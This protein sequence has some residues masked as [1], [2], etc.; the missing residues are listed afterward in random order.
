TIN[1]LAMDKTGQIIDLFNGKQDLKNKIIRTVGNG[2]ER[3]SED[4]LR[5]IRAIR[6][7]SQLGFTISDKTIENIKKTKEDI[8]ALEAERITNEITKLFRGEYV[9]RGIQYIK[10]T[11]IGA[12]LPTFKQHPEVMDRLPDEVPPTTSFG[13]VIAL[14][15]LL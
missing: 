15:H 13:P 10:I 6:F 9:K 12:H 3:F 4:P 14:F 11:E 1:A 8:E 2:E 7:S 5:M